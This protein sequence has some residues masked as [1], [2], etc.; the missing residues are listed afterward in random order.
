MATG[1]HMLVETDSSIKMNQSQDHGGLGDVYAIPQESGNMKNLGILSPHGLRKLISRK[2][3]YYLLLG[4]GVQR[5]GE[6]RTM[7]SDPQPLCR[8][9]GNPDSSSH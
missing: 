4:K 7:R 8:W 9:R 3:S 5:H 1:Y 6:F 2:G